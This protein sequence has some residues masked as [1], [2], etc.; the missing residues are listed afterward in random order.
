MYILEFKF[1]SSPYIHIRGR[2]PE[3]VNLVGKHGQNSLLQVSVNE[4][5]IVAFLATHGQTRYDYT[6]TGYQ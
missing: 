5:T 1:I 2:T 3:P 6:D 4:V